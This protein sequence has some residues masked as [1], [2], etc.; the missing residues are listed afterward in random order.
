MRI[1]PKTNRRDIRIIMDRFFVIA[2]LND[3]G[4]IG[5]AL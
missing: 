2:K 1:K 5:T 4:C 3:I